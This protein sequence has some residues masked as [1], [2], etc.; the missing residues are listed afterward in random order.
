MLKALYSSADEGGS[1]GKSSDKGGFKNSLK[2]I[3]M[4]AFKNT[5]PMR[6]DFRKLKQ[7][8]FK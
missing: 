1:D 8:I 4:S 3:A 5:E 7:N 6:K 2:K